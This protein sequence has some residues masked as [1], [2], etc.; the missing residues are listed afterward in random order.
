MEDLYT[1][2]DIKTLTEKM[3]AY[4]SHEH[5]SHADCIA[6]FLKITT[7]ENMNVWLALSMKSVCSS[8]DFWWAEPLD[9]MMFRMPLEEIPM[10]L[11]V[12]V[13]GEVAKW[14]LEIGK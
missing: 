7:L 5:R 4:G 10:H 3:G 6:S 2:M 12:P 14:R 8:K 1:R 9:L 11:N 13:Y